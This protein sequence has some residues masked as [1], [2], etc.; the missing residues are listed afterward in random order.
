MCVRMALFELSIEGWASVTHWRRCAWRQLAF[1]ERAC[2]RVCVCSHPCVRGE[3]RTVTLPA[4]LDS[5][6]LN[7][8]QGTSAARCLF[9]VSSPSVSSQQPPS[10]QPSSQFH[11]SQFHELQHQVPRAIAAWET[12]Q[13]LLVSHKLKCEKARVRRIVG[14]LLIRS[15]HRRWLR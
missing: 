15:H 7:R 11:E 3:V 8:V 4:W 12:H 5:V 2:V 9:S 6:H 1:T 13:L 10:Q 14:V